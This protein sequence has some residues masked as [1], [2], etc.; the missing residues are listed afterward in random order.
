MRYNFYEFRLLVT[1]PEGVTK[2]EDEL[3]AIEEAIKN[4]KTLGLDDFS[5]DPTEKKKKVLD[6]KAV[7]FYGQVLYGLDVMELAKVLVEI[8]GIG[9]SCLKIDWFCDNSPETTK[10]ANSSQNI[11]KEGKYGYT[12]YIINGAC[13]GSLICY[14]DKEG[15]ANIYNLK[16]TGTEKAP[17]KPSWV[18]DED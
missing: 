1:F 18:T 8:G 2:T 12:K 3:F 14:I 17:Y 16:T 5:V 7:V 10:E 4:N 9:T 13:C 6:K 11:E 15:K